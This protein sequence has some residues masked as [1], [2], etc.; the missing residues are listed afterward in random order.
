MYGASLGSQSSFHD[1]NPADIVAASYAADSRRQSMAHP[2]D[3]QSTETADGKGL[4]HGMAR[5]DDYKD[6][7][8]PKMACI[9]TA[10][11]SLGHVFNDLC[12][13]CWFTYLQ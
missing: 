12:A 10:A 3:Y 4:L 9:V 1:R 5:S 13:A 11:Y 8:P 6:T 2:D 7:E